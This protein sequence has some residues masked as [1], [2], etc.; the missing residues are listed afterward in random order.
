LGKSGHELPQAPQL[1]TSL[2]R[3]THS[4]PHAVIPDPQTQAPPEQPIAFLHTLE[5]APQL[6]TLV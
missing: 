1:F 3:L 5:Q 6:P 4:W 2:F